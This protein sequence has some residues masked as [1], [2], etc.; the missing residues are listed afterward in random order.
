LSRQAVPQLRLEKTAEN[1]SARGAYVIRQLGGKERDLTILATGTEVEIAVRAGEQLAEEGLSVAVVSMP[2]WELFE[3][4]STAYRDGVL[5]SAPR[6][7]IEAAAKFGWTRY[8]ASEHDVIGLESFG[9]SAPGEVVYEKMGITADA[10]MARA[11]EKL[12]IRAANH[13]GHPRQ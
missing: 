12:N 10:L 4:E 8:V 11:R 1:L 7:A 5:G 6:V 13:R 2:C 9:H 3:A